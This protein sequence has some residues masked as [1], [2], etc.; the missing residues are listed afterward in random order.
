MTPQRRVALKATD[1]NTHLELLRL[2][3][4][5]PS[6]I[7]LL[8]HPVDLDERPVRASLSGEKSVEKCQHQFDRLKVKSDGYLEE[9]EKAN[10][11]H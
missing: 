4:I 8:P 10:P 2:A 9:G 1:F 11:Y 3:R 5:L 6:N 7:F